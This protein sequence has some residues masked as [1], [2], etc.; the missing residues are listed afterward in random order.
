MRKIRYKSVRFWVPAVFHAEIHHYQIMDFSSQVTST[1]IY[2][3]HKS[4]G[5]VQVVQLVTIPPELRAKAGLQPVPPD[6][7]QDRIRQKPKSK[8][9]R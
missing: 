6:P 4:T 2:Q 9:Y 5:P 8:F 3:K 7:E 1:E